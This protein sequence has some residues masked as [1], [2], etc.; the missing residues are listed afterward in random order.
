MYTPKIYIDGQE[1]T[2]GLR[3]RAMLQLRQDLELELIPAAERKNIE[4]RSRFLNQADLVVLCLPDEAATE[5]LKLIDNP[6]TRIIDT[7]TIRRIHPEWIYGL[8]ELSPGQREAIGKAKRVANCGCYPV[9]FTL[10]VRPLI[11]AGLL[12]PSARFT[13]NAVSGYSGG[14]RKMIE[15]YEQTPRPD[16]AT[17]AAMPLCLY[18][19]EE[20]HKHVPEMQKFGLLEHPPLFVPSVAHAYCGML[21]STPLTAAHGIKAGT[22][23]QQIHEV[24]RNYYRNAPFVR[25][26]PPADNDQV[27]RDGKF[28]DLGDCNFTNKVEL[29]A[30]GDAA[31]GLLLV[32][33]LDNL[34]KGAS[35]NAV[36]CLNLMLGFDERT[37]LLS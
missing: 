25:P 4:V 32:G 30:F 22:T 21:V 9:G 26:V 11:Q 1:G 15:A 16:R 33:R 8:P 19:L 27:L 20:R 31:H 12:D 13:I 23:P 18:S 7:S 2:T 36:Q 10:A 14:G 5:A 17:D 29:F 3:L 37:G 24:W 6:A 34:G 35:G 28:L